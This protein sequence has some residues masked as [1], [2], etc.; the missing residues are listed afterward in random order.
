MGEQTDRVRTF[1]TGKRKT[2]Q[3]RREPQRKDKKKSKRKGGREE[4]Q[5][6]N[7]PKCGSNDAFLTSQELMLES[8]ITLKFMRWV[9]WTRWVIHF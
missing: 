4:N 8:V 3:Q 2:D 5:V 1:I 6:F 7:S 9:T